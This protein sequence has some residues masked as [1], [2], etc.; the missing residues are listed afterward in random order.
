[1]LAKLLSR[2]W[3]M[4]L[5]RGVVSILFG[6]VALRTPGITLATLVLFFGAYVLVEGV[7]GSVQAIS[8]RSE[9]EH[10]VAML[11]SGLLGILLGVLTFMAPG[12]TALVLLFYIAIWALLTG[13]LEMV[14]AVRL[15]KEIHGEFWLFLAGLFS[16]LFGV[17][18][19][20]RPGAGALAVILYI[21]IWA[22][23]TGVFTTVLAFRVR[24]F[25]KQLQSTGVAGRA[26]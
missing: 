4:L 24:G 16:V 7:F 2:T 13:V 15:R 12:V 25:G 22:I 5:L 23:V 26:G 1:M 10:W 17:L 18:L 11:F 19:V 8:G 9:N 6:I 20:S 3:W 14:L 21:G